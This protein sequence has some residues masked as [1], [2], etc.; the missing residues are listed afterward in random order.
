MAAEAQVEKATL[1]INQRRGNPIREIWVLHLLDQLL[2]QLRKRRSGG[3]AG[4]AKKE[5]FYVEAFVVK[6]KERI[7]TYM[8]AG[9]AK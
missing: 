2:G 7:G 3:V 1:H 8:D 4:R 5:D 6:G 9:R